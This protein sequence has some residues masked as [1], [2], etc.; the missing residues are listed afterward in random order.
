MNSE[1]I[2]ETFWMK[3]NQSKLNEIVK[4]RKIEKILNDWNKKRVQNESN[5][6]FFRN[7]HKEHGMFFGKVVYHQNFLKN[8]LIHGNKF[9]DNEDSFKK[10]TKFDEE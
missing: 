5:L 6:T 3:K 7:R 8:N 9:I 4:K 10:F 1:N 2:C